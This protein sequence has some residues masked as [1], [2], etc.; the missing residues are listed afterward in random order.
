M[1]MQFSYQMAPEWIIKDFIVEK[2]TVTPGAVLIDN[3]WPDMNVSATGTRIVSSKGSINVL[4]GCEGTETLLLLIA[5]LLAS[6]VIGN[7]WRKVII[8][9]IVGSS[10]VYV[11]N[12]IR[13]AALFYIV[14]KH[15]NYFEMAHGYIA[16]LF[17]IG[18]STIFFI[19]WLKLSANHMSK[20]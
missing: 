10:I 5:A 13:I 15:R 6:L 11:V 17:V 3:L 4:R 18:I 12:Q 7:S 2:A 19:L 1:A 9:I 8:G 16:P 14:V 20:T